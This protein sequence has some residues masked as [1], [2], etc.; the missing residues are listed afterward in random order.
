MQFQN[1]LEE[2][3]FHKA[4][5]EKELVELGGKGCEKATESGDETSNL[6]GALSLS[7]L[8]STYSLTTPVNRV[9]FLLQNEMVIGDRRRETERDRGA[10]QAGSKG[11]F[12]HTEDITNILIIYT[13]PLIY[14]RQSPSQPT[15]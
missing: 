5:A 3:T 4:V 12:T 7:S 15:C 8:S 11:W 13:F 9:D 1:Y 6:L 10:S 2:K 14:M